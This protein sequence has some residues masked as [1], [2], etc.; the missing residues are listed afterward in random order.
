MRY[1][2]HLRPVVVAILVLGIIHSCKQDETIELK[3][4]QLEILEHPK[5]EGMTQLGKKLEIPFTVENMQKA[6]NNMINNVSLKKIV[7]LNKTKEKF[8]IEASHYYHRFLPRDTTEYLRLITDS[9]LDIVNVPLHYEVIEA[10][11]GFRDPSLPLEAPYSYQYS[12]FPVDYEF[13]KEIVHEKLEELYFPPEQ[14][15]DLE[16]DEI[17]VYLPEDKTSR[18]LKA[19]GEPFFEIL[20][21]EVL[22]VTGNLDKEEL[23]SLD[24]IMASGEKIGFDQLKKKGLSLEDV[25]IDYSNYGEGSLS[26]RRWSPN[27]RV[28]VS[29]D[30]IGNRRVGVKGA[31]I[32]VRK[33]GFLVI[34][35]ART[36]S[37]GYFRTSS[38]RTKR[39]KYAVYFNSPAN[40]RVMQGTIFVAARHRGTRKYK[41]KSWNQHFTYGRAHLYSLVQ[42]AAL[43]YYTQHVPTYGLRRPRYTTISAKYN[44]DVRSEHRPAINV[45]ASDI[46]VTRISGGRYRGSDGIYATTTHELTHAS[47]RELDPGIFSV[48]AR[49]CR[50]NMLMESWAEGVETIITNAR[51][52]RYN[53]NY[54]N[55]LNNI[56]WNDW[57]QR[58]QVKDMNEY[59]PI[60]IDLIDRFN[61]NTRN[62]RWPV[63]NVSGYSLRQI[64]AA[65]DNS[66]SPSTW[67]NKLNNNRPPGVTTA[68]LNQLFAYMDR[69]LQNSQT[70]D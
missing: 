64:Q 34:K 38:T 8:N 13:P 17:P 58:V 32:K 43:D 59:T 39:V 21:T 61:Q 7:S 52:D 41:R 36:N 30:A 67:R 11:E 68:E 60:V 55:D 45:F 2:K 69:A 25:A 35:R 40:F 42:N 33:W 9:I 44:R 47:H 10:G 46:R 16:E 6:Y 1:Y 20:E 66:R 70:C 22:K 63:D 37:S 62:T 27:G 50:R 15:T 54:F 5:L 26:A 28:T 51:Y 56:G 31:E 24:Y 53:S 23:G 57:R 14:K 65:L 29:E 4:E 49:S 19:Y 3:T 18:V 48:V 12:V